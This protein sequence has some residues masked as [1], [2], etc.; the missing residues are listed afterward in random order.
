MSSNFTTLPMNRNETTTNIVQLA[1]L[2]IKP[3]SSFPNDVFTLEQRRNGAIILHV[4][5]AVYI[6]SKRVF[7][8]FIH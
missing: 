4:I 6:I 8:T 3:E 5:I 7:F 1:C 2:I